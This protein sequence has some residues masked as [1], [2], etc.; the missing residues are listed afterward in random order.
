[1]SRYESF[2]QAGKLVFQKT[3]EPGSSTFVKKAVQQ[4]DGSW[5][6]YSFYLGR[7]PGTPLRS[8]E[9]QSQILEFVNEVKDQLK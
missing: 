6:L 1:M 7:G 2:T 8:K 4:S 3:Y 5:W 9:R